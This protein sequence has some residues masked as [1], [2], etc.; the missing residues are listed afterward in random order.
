MIEDQL[1]FLALE[2]RDAGKTPAMSPSGDFPDVG[3]RNVSVSP[4]TF[5]KFD[6]AFVLRHGRDVHPTWAKSIT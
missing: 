1:V 3:G 5:G 6:G 4:R 2:G